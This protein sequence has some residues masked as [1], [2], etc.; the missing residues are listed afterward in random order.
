[1]ISANEARKRTM[2]NAE[3]KI[4]IEELE[5]EI[6]ISIRNGVYKA[7]IYHELYAINTK[8]LAIKELLVKLLED[9]GYCVVFTWAKERPANCRDDLWV[10]ENGTMEV[11]WE[12]S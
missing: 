11:S 1:M 9:L 8:D 2:L 12:E 4:Y 7:T 6:E 10:Y 5:K 3:A